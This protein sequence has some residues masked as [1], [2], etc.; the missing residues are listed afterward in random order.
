MIFIIIAGIINLVTQSTLLTTPVAPY[1]ADQ[2]QTRLGWGATVEPASAGTSAANAITALTDKG[3]RDG[4]F[5][6]VGDPARYGNPSMAKGAVSVRALFPE[7]MT[8]GSKRKLE[9]AIR[10]GEVGQEKTGKYLEFALSVER[11]ASLAAAGSVGPF[12]PL[13]E[14][15][16]TLITLYVN[17]GDRRLREMVA[18]LQ[19]AWYQQAYRE[20]ARR[21]PVA[22]TFKE[23][24][25]S[26]DVTPVYQEIAKGRTAIVNPSSWESGGIMVRILLFVLVLC[27]SA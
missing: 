18:A 11:N 5:A 25:N 21:D 8:F 9:D 17:D 4:L 1:P 20:M 6:R 23:N 26:S 14:S 22:F 27:Y 3:L 24:D 19:S 13:N 2:L 10:A 7:G 12:R 16:D 15:A